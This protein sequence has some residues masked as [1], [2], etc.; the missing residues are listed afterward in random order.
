MVPPLSSVFESGKKICELIL[1]S[2]FSLRLQTSVYFVKIFEDKTKLWF[3]CYKNFLFVKI[4][5]LS[6]YF[7]NY[8]HLMMK[9]DLVYNRNIIYPAA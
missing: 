1:G 3:L 8:F 2:L 5:I 6:L 7:E 4:I 9:Y